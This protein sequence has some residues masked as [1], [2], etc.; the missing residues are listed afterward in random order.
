LVIKVINTASIVTLFIHITQS[1][2]KPAATLKTLFTGTSN[3]LGEFESGITAAYFGV[4][5]A[6]VLGGI[7]TLTVVLLWI[8]LFPQLFKVNKLVS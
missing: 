4:V 2:T 5:P 6:V 3:Q 8:K 7:G 1:Q